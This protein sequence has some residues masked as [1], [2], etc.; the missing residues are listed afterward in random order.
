MIELG[1]IGP[2]PHTAMMLADLGAD[3]VRVRRPGGLTMPAEN[4]DLL[5]MEATY[6]SDL[7][8]LAVEHGHCTAPDT[9]RIAAAAGARRLAMTHFSTRYTTTDAHLREANGIHDDVIALED[10]DR[11]PVDP[12][13]C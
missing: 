2:G 11:V 12:A 10:L 1:G 8:E 5:V 6:T 13:I 3:V 4:V 7:Q 9:A